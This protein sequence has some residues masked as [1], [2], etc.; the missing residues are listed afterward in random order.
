[1]KVSGWKVLNSKARQQ[2]KEEKIK[3]NPSRPRVDVRGRKRG[4]VRGRG[5]FHTS[6]EGQVVGKQRD[7]RH[8]IEGEKRS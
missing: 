8:I 5:V 3:R 7:K 4:V 1:L 6:D 2:S